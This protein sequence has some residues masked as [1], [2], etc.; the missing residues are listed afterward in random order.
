MN[1]LLENMLNHRSCR[2]YS[3]K[4]VPEEL[5]QEL[6]RAAQMAPTSLFMQSYSIIRVDDPQQREALYEASGRQPW[7]LEAPV[8]LLYLADLYRSKHFLPD[9]DEKALRNTEM[10]TVAVTDTAL[11]AQNFA[12]AAESRDLGITFVGGIR[13]NPEAII[14]AFDLP[15]LVFPLFVQCVGY[16][17]ECNDLEPRLNPEIILHR[18]RYETEKLDSLLDDYNRHMN[19]YY[20]NR[21]IEGDWFEHVAIKVAKKPRFHM[22]EAVRNQGF[23]TVDTSPET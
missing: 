1:N 3:D 8:V 4:E 19:H 10:Y 9:I 18:D 2:R 22:D 6:F 17:D 11:V 23:L 20:K 16:P 5:L 21:G 12:I 7:I 14:R 13:D 15:E